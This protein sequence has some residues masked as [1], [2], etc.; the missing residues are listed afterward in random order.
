MPHRY[1]LLVFALLLALPSQAQT[2][3]TVNVVPNTSHPDPNARFEVYELDGVQGLEL[4]LVR[5][6]TYVFQMDGTPTNHPFYIST[7]EVGAGAEVY[8]NGVTGNFATG[9]EALTF[10]VPEDAPDLLYYQCQFHQRMGWQINI[11]DNTTATE[12]E[13]QPLALRLDAAYP[14]P[15]RAETSVRLALD[16]PRV[17]AVEAFDAA[18]RHV[19]TLHAGM[20]AAGQPHTFTFDAAGLA[21][22]LYVI[23][24]TAGAT[25]VERRVALVR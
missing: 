1:L 5:G 12:D 7:S 24:A 2:T 19:A 10:T 22:G 21:D 8:E 20:L 11:V 14:N 4:E 16:A 17:V 15:F 3:F 18:G 25:V 23:R 6:G 13:A 9:N